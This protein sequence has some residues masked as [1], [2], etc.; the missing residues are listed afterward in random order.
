MTDHL[1]A[2]IPNSPAPFEEP[3]PQDPIYRALRELGIHTLRISYSG[4]NDSGSI[5]EVEAHD[6]KGRPVDLP[7]TPVS[8]TLTHATY[9]FQTGTYAAEKTQTKD[10]PLSEAV[11]QWCYDLLEEHYPGWEI[12][13]GSDGIIVIDPAKRKGNIDHIQY[14]CES[15]YRS[16]Q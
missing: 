8:Y 15:N 10:L 2:V 1:P 7:P 14:F 5:N 16:F 12:D 13:E 4:S 6:Q 11:E 3:R 9:D